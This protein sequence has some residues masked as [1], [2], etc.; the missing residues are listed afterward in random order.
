MA[1]PNKDLKKEVES[2]RVELR[3]L[4]AELED[5]EIICDTYLNKARGE[6]LH[7]CLEPVVVNTEHLQENEMRIVRDILRISGLPQNTILNI[8]HHYG[9]GKTAAIIR[10]LDRCLSISHR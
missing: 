1:S 6:L 7:D 10:R 3:H 8:F 4:E 9:N 5:M 2:L